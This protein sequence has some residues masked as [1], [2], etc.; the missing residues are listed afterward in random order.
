MK[1]VPI[2]KPIA[3]INLFSRN[4]RS[5]TLNQNLLHAI[6]SQSCISPKS[7]MYWKLLALLDLFI[8]LA[9]ITTDVQFHD[10]VYSWGRASPNHTKLFIDLY[11]F[12]LLVEYLA[13]WSLCGDN[14]S[15]VFSDDL[16]FLK[17]PCWEEAQPFE[18]EQSVF[19][20]ELEG[21][22][23]SKVIVRV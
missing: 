6:Q 20:L 2:A 15:I 11:Q 16:A 12:V 17:S 13:F 4:Y 21:V 3:N 1:K 14:W 7:L 19:C 22:W 10:I 9:L 23:V 5:H 8:L 18:G